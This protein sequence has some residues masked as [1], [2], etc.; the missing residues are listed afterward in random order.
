MSGLNPFAA[1]PVLMQ[2]WLEVGL[3]AGG[4]VEKREAA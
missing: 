4:S 2:S 3:R 1:L